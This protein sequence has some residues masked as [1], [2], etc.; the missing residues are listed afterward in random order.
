MTDKG[1]DMK[2][3]RKL[4]KTKLPCLIVYNCA[5]HTLHNLCCD[6]V[7]SVSEVRYGFDF[8]KDITNYSRN[9]NVAGAYIKDALKER[10]LRN[11]VQP[12]ITRWGTAAACID[13]VV[14][15]R[16]AL[17]SVAVSTAFRE[18]GKT[19]AANKEA[20]DELYKFVIT[21][22]AA[23]FDAAEQA[24][25]GAPG[26]ALG[27]GGLALNAHPQPLQCWATSPPPSTCWKRTRPAS[28][29]STRS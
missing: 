4:M 24:G 18:Y 6:I 25:L 27:V 7:S 13:G 29:S 14:K 12:V 11:L 9:R 10:G 5:P 22:G 3:M 8:A 1:S 20:F 28:R 19:A 17:A 16:D 26:E 23:G 2:G 15:A 21:N